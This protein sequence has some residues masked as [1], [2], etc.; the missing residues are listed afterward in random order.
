M[1]RISTQRGQS[2]TAHRFLMGLVV[3]ASVCSQVSADEKS[4]SAATQERAILMQRYVVSATRVEKSPWRYAALPGFEVLSRASDEK[5]KWWLD[6]LRRGLWIENAVLPKDWLPQSPVPDTVIIDDTDLEAIPTNQLRSQEVTLQTPGDALTWGGLSEKAN[7]WSDRFDSH[8]NDTWAINVDLYGVDIEKP[9]CVMGLGRVFHCA[10][11]L[12]RWLISGM[13]GTKSGVFRE[14]FMPVLEGEPGALVRSAEGPGTLWESLDETKKLKTL[15]KRDKK[16]KTPIPPLGTLFSDAGPTDERTALWESEAGLFVRWGLLGPGH[17]DP[18]LS[19]AFLELVNRGRR[20]PITEP[21]FE[22][23]FGFGYAA[24]EVRL[25][26]FLKVALAQPTSVSLEMPYSFPEA[27][28][29]P[30]TA[31]QIGRIIGDWLRMQGDSLRNKDPAMS[32]EF[33]GSS[34]RM[35]ERAYR[36]DNGLP[37]DVNPVHQS[38]QPESALLKSNPGS[39]VAMKPF[40]VAA[41]RIHDPGLLAV[42]GMY[43]LDVGID[44]KARELLGA[45]ARSG[46]VRPRAQIALAKLRY[47]EAI[48]KPLGSQGKF[49]AQQI[50]SIL[51]PLNVALETPAPDAYG[52]FVQTMER[53]E[54]RPDICEIRTLVEGATLF[55]RYTSLAC[56]A[57]LVCAQNGFTEQAANIGQTALAFSAD[58]DSRRNLERL[59]LAHGVALRP[60]TEP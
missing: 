20:E 31:D 57:A 16:A 7:I 27:E 40:I 43:E 45:A 29:K 19:R 10:P 36:E 25:E 54:S 51:E 17:D 6:A 26:S 34:G 50:A 35:L 22:E 32:A 13:L 28:M 8:D 60:I 15:L 44:E 49:S 42:Y 37:P 1:A 41:I 9:A 30:A 47:A 39:V 38:E 3:L 4:N 18:A 53:D 48:G 21:V 59:H 55:P 12:P 24:M 56:Q 23:C 2:T 58:K 52:I 5:T 46:V 33:L 14:S 11:S